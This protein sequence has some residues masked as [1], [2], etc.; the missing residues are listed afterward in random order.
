[1][2]IIE[3]S[4]E[5]E[6]GYRICN[7]DRKEWIELSGGI[8]RHCSSRS[9][10]KISIKDILSDK[11]VSERDFILTNPTVVR[12]AF[13]DFFENFDESECDNV[14]EI[15]DKFISKIRS[16]LDQSKVMDLLAKLGSLQANDR[17]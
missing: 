1:M 4:K 9:E 11:W 6:Q 8:F 5:A 17:Q 2:N 12:E 10:A 13:E 15:A 14:D 7:E 3:A 16:G